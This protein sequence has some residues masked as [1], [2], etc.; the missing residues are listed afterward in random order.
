MAAL[1]E[2]LGTDLDG[3]PGRLTELGGGPRRLGDLNPDRSR[4][5]AVLDSIH[6]R[7]TAAMRD[8]LTREELAEMVEG[9]M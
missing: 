3:L 2:A 5:E 9:A 8:P 6:A 1:A 4:L 7:I